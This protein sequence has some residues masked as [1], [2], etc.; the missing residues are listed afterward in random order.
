MCH[1][2]CCYA[3][4]I[5]V[6]L[7]MFYLKKIVERVIVEEYN[8]QRMYITLCLHANYIYNAMLTIPVLF[9]I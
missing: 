9:V 6:K 5:F 1:I 3:L 2:Q 8:Y 7:M 4:L